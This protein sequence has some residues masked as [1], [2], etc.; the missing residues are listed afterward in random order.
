MHLRSWAMILQFKPSQCSITWSLNRWSRS[1]I[2]WS[3][4]QHDYIIYIWPQHVTTSH[5]IMW[6][7]L[8]VFWVC[9]GQV[10][11][12]TAD[13]IVL[14]LPNLD[15]KVAEMVCETATHLRLYSW[16][17]ESI[18]VFVYFMII[19][20]VVFTMKIGGWDKYKNWGNI[21]EKWR[22]KWGQ[23]Y[24]PSTIGGTIPLSPYKYHP[25]NTSSIYQSINTSLIYN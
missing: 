3:N 8:I 2:T 13:I 7:S 19:H 21:Y 9:G 11:C 12:P 4:Y 16:Y 10:R 15:G 23:I 20:R 1:M 22:K 18:H 17:V 25:D 14:L 5:M 6:W 24:F